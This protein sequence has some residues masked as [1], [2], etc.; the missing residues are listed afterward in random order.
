[1]DLGADLPLTSVGTFFDALMAEVHQCG[2]I[3][4]RI[5]DDWKHILPSTN[6]DSDRENLD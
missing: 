1:M 6:P 3:V 4:I 2:W 5:K